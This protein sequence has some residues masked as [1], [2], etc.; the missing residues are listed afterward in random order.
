MTTNGQ[1]KLTY[2][3]IAA[4][5]GRFNR[6]RKVAPICT[7]RHPHRT[8]SAPCWVALSISTAGHVRPC[9]VPAPFRPILPLHVWGSGL[10]LI[11]G[12]LGRVRY[13]RVVIPNYISIGSAV[14][15]GLTIMT[16]R[17]TNQQSD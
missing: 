13:S 10:H 7:H 6:I 8:G 16:D 11:H 3:R 14:F 4:A 2:G 12:S 9:P 15:A 17:R 5:H 1:S